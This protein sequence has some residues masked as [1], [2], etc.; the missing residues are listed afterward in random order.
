VNQ[1][2]L[3]TLDEL[4]KERLTPR[5]I[6]IVNRISELYV[7][8]RLNDEHLTVRA[9]KMGVRVNSNFRYTG[10]GIILFAIVGG[11]WKMFM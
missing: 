7:E 9:N 2:K 11:F 10:L 1:D 8:I 4:T 6:G 5:L 3:V